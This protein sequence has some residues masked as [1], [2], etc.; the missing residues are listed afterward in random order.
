MDPSHCSI[1]VLYKPTTTNTATTTKTATPYRIQL[2]IEDNDDDFNHQDNEN[3]KLD[4]SYSGDDRPHYLTILQSVFGHGIELYH[5]VIWRNK[6]I[7]WFFFNIW[8][9][10][11]LCIYFCSV[12]TIGSC[13]CNTTNSIST[14][15]NF[16]LDRH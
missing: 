16:M 12:H 4:D 6:S 15:A 3:S 8:L 9:Y 1:V 7:F 13:R 2:D 5:N 11:Y 14:T 10:L